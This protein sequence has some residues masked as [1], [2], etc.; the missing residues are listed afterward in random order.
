MSELEGYARAEELQQALHR[1]QRALADERRRKDDLASAVYRA[2][3]DAALGQP[4]PER[5]PQPKKGKP[6]DHW[7]LLHL[8]DW[9]LGKQTVDYNREVCERRVIQAVETALRLVELQRSAYGVPNCAVLL[10]G[11]MVEGVSIFPGQAWEVDGSLYDQ[12]FACSRLIERVIRTLLGE[13]HRVEVWCEWGNHGRLGRKGDMPSADNSD[14]MAYRIAQDRLAGEKRL[15]WHA[16]DDFYQLGQ[17]GAYRFLLV[18]GDEVKGF[19]GNIPA[20][21]IVRKATSWRSGVLEEFADVYMG[22][23]H[24]HQ[25]LPLPNGG[26]IF[27]TGSPESSNAYAKEFCAAGGAPSQ[28]LHFVDPE[29]GRV[30]AES[31]LW[32]D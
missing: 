7:A 27:I 21:G 30:V 23:W 13:F 4:K 32:L 16:S 20:F 3:K 1:A 11:D 12:L 26:S 15:A 18:H 14:R 31:R 28:R 8:T 10:G 5:I 24:Q 2:A 9:Q 17:I 19:G 6:G 25:Q 22:H 29:R